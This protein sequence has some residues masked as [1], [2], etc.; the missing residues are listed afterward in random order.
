MDKGKCDVVVLSFCSALILTIGAV[1]ADGA[2]AAK[3][4]GGNAKSPTM[5]QEQSVAPH[6]EVLREN[7]LQRSLGAV[8]ACTSHPAEAVADAVHVNIHAERR[9][10]ESIDQ[11]AVGRLAANAGKFQ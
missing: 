6:P 3:R 8:R 11:K 10:V 4:N 1:R 7:L 9:F 5:L 2:A